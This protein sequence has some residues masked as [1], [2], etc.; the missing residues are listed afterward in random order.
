[1]T[2]L[3]NK[4][5]VI[6]NHIKESIPCLQDLFRAEEI[7]IESLL[8]GKSAECGIKKGGGIA[9][10][11]LVR[12]E[13]LRFLCTDSLVLS[14]ADPRGIHIRNA[15]IKCGFD[16]DRVAK[17]RG[18]LDIDLDSTNIPFTLYLFHCFIP[19]G[20]QCRDAITKMIALPGCNVSKLKFDRIKSNGPVWLCSTKPGK[21]NDVIYPFICNGELS[22]NSAVINGDLL[23]SGGQ[24]GSEKID[25][26]FKLSVKESE[27]KGTLSLADSMISGEML[28]TDTKTRIFKDS[29]KA[30]KSLRNY[31]IDGFCYERIL[32][33]DNHN[34]EYNNFKWRRE[35]WVSSQKLSR[36]FKSQP[37]EQLANVLKKEGYENESINV[38]VS[39]QDSY[40][41]HKIKQAGFIYWPFLYVQKLS[42]KYLAGYGYKPIRA[43]VFISILWVVCSFLYKSLYE[44]GCIGPGNPAIYWRDEYSECK[45]NWSKCDKKIQG[46]PSFIPLVYSLDVL[47]PFVDFKQNNNWIPYDSTTCSSMPWILYWIETVLGWLGSFFFLALAS[48][49]VKIK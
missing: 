11:G 32:L 27:I 31:N 28:L 36:T 40:F 25:S 15:V 49:L 41:K 35:V 22:I 48:G 24:Y 17:Q 18:D 13:V 10:K 2:G 1:M 26:N 42:W 30:Y 8:Y 4:L 47:I 14:N 34:L 19:G 43:F 16:K 44:E 39:K 5:Q 37:F 21:N 33:M 29:E 23:L 3:N 12:A 38:L 45:K 20:I 9:C 7:V 46:Y 6:F